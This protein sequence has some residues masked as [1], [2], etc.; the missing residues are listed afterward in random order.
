MGMNHSQSL[1][2]ASVGQCLDPTLYQLR[3]IVLMSPEFSLTVQH[4]CQQLRRGP[5]LILILVGQKIL[6]SRSHGIEWFVVKQL[7]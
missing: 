3:V 2:C 6:E 1:P 7:N 4:T 5:L